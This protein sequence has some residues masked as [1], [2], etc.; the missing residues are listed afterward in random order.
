[1]RAIDAD[2]AAWTIAVS[3]GPGTGQ[4]FRIARPSRLLIDIHDTEDSVHG[5]S[6]VR[7]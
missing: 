1:V 6:Y 7:R 3:N 2:S 5:T 4:R